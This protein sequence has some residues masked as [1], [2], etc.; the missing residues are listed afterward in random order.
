MFG[1]Y[2]DSPQKY[3]KWVKIMMQKIK[4][5]ERG[6]FEQVSIQFQF[7]LCSFED[8]KVLYHFGNLRISAV[9]STL[10]IFAEFFPPCIWEQYI[11]L[12]K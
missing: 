4:S 6:W 10:L 5:I 1:N 8:F 12:V 2:R 9:P 11:P 3:Q 7:I